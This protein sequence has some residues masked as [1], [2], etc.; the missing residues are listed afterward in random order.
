MGNNDVSNTDDP[1]LNAMI[2]QTKQMPLGARPKRRS[3]PRSTTC[4]CRRTPGWVPILH[5][6]QPT[7]TSARLHGLVFTG[8]YFELIPSMWCSQS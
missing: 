7:F 5:L 3:G 2:D 4:S 8:S 1:T 6:Q